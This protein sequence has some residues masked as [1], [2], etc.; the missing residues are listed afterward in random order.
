[1]S[2]ITIDFDAHTRNAWGT[3][4]AVD[5]LNE[6]FEHVL[7]DTVEMPQPRTLDVPAP[8]L[9]LVRAEL[10]TGEP[11]S[12]T[13]RVGEGP[14]PAVAILTAAEVSP[15]ETLAWAYARQS[16]RNVSGGSLTAWT[17]KV[18]RQTADSGGLDTL[19]V[20]IPGIF[21]QVVGPEWK[22]VPAAGSVNADAAVANQDPRLVV[23][24][25]IDIP[26]EDQVAE[27]CGPVYVQRSIKASPDA[28]AEIDVIAVPTAVDPTMLFVRN[29]T[30]GPGT[31]AIRTLVR[32]ANP[33]AEG[34]LAYLNNG[35]FPSAKR[36]AQAVTVEALRTMADT[37][38]DPFAA[39]IAGYFRLSSGQIG[40]LDWMRRLTEWFPMMPD[41]PVICGVAVLRSGTD[42]ASLDEARSYLLQAVERGIPT[43]TVG[44]RL[45]FDALRALA[46]RAPNDHELLSAVAR[47]RAV[48]ASTEWTSQTTTFSFD[49]LSEHVPLKF[50]EPAIA[51]S[52]MINTSS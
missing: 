5:V 38:R 32:G 1:V 18:A 22:F 52:S 10:P 36:I 30:Q 28:P 2:R 48:A 25:K 14:D 8:G 49:R 26:E 45:L 31:R 16:V 33:K 24:V 19:S 27:R 15:R 29:E 23:Q 34:L 17:Q 20:T 9:Y 7:S 39:A 37:R 47:V 11:V 46:E 6:R 21:R 50:A 40:R 42:D 4:V 41:G 13:V 12:T 35:A 51:G 44:L 3:L 43:Y